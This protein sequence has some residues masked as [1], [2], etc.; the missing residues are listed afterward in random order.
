MANSTRTCKNCF[1]KYD[2]NDLHFTLSFFEYGAFCSRVCSDAAN[3]ASDRDR[4]FKRDR[5]SR[6]RRSDAMSDEGCL[7]ILIGVLLLLGLLVKSIPQTGPSKF[8]LEKK[9][10]EYKFDTYPL[11]ENYLYRA[12]IK[13]QLGD[14]SGAE[15]DEK[16]AN[17]IKND[18]KKWYLWC[19]KRLRQHE[20]CML[21]K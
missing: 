11:K 14:I 17:K 13:R 9:I 3:K 2:L 21:D 19:K 1:R 18:P 15:K 7:G 16:I 4:E 12:K 6:P 8:T 20:N 10:S 5:E